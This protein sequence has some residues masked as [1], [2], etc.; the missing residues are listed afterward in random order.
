[1]GNAEQPNARLYTARALRSAR[2]PIHMVATQV[3][4][5]M[6]NNGRH[7]LLIGNRS[8]LFDGVS[9]LLQ[10]EGYHVDDSSN[11][12]RTTS[13]ANGD[14][15]N[16]AIVDIS[17]SGPAGAP[18]A[19]HIKRATQ[20]GHVP[21]LVLGFDGD[22]RMLALQRDLHGNGNSR[23]QFYAHTLLGGAGLLDKVNACLT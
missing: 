13:A 10:L 18:L 17:S 11:W 7:I 12:A 14:R 3:T 9:D 19:E 5:T 2:C 22:P 4:G 21:I 6:T 1:M 8:P 23:I 15:P 20:Q 16:L